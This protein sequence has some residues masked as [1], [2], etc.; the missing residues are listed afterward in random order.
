MNLRNCTRASHFIARYFA[1]CFSG[2]EEGNKMQYTNARFRLSFALLQRN[3]CLH[4]VPMIYGGIIRTQLPF[5]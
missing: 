1:V 2:F 3:I 5:Q 4:G